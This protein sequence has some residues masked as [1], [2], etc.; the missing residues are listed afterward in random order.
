MIQRDYTNLNTLPKV[1]NMNP[2]SWI[3][4]IT[5]STLGII[6]FNLPN[7]INENY[8]ILNCICF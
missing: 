5:L 8:L 3:F 4:L 2:Q 7:L 6:L 1:K